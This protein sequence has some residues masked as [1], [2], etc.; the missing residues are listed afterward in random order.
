MLTTTE[1]AIALGVKPGTVRALIKRG[2][3]KATR[4]GRDHAISPQEVERY[5]HERQLP[6]RPKAPRE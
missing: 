3:L 5:L 2:L 1:A 6:G 4:H